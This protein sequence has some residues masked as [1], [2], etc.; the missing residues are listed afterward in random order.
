MAFWGAGS[1]DRLLLKAPK[2][3][4]QPAIH[5]ILQKIKTERLHVPLDSGRFY[6]AT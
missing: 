5:L 3:I 4:K 1:I 2:D 6:Y